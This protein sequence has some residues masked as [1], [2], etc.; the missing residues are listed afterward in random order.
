LVNLLTG[1]LT[2]RK[3]TSLT[4]QRAHTGP[5]QQLNAELAASGRHRPRPLPQKEDH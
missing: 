3:T 4:V 1:S 5:F 2:A